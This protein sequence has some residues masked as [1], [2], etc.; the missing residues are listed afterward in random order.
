MAALEMGNQ[1]AILSTLMILR[2]PG[3]TLTLLKAKRDP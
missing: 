1:M 2:T 3:S